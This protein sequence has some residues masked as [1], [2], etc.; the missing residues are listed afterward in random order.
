M[1]NERA[2][3]GYFLKDRIGGKSWGMDAWYAARHWII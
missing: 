1:W 3:I 2:A